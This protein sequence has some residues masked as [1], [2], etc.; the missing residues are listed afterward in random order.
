MIMIFVSGRTTGL[1]HL[2]A[3]FHSDCALY[4]DSGFQSDSGL[5]QG[6]SY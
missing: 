1:D 2:S 6:G 3:D 4:P 5:S